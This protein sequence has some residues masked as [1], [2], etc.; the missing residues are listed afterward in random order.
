MSS[1]SSSSSES[2]LSDSSP[3]LSKFDPFAVH[4]FTNCSVNQNGSKPVNPTSYGYPYGPSFG[5]YNLRR[6]Q[7]QPQVPPPNAP[8]AGIFVPFRKDTPSPDLAD[9]LK[10]NKSISKTSSSHSDATSS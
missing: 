6:V 1:S 7:P 8:P 4:P 9:V 5:N 3:S 2:S 10:S